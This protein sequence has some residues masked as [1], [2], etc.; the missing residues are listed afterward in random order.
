M[1]YLLDG[2]DL[3]LQCLNFFLKRLQTMNQPWKMTLFWI[4]SFDCGPRLHTFSSIF[5]HKLFKCIKLVDVA[6][7]HSLNMWKMNIVSLYWCSWRISGKIALLA[8]WI[9]ICVFCTMILH[10][11]K[12][13]FWRGHQTLEE[14][15]GTI[16]PWCVQIKKYFLK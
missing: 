14:H 3:D 5:K 16:L 8:I 13:S 1:E 12:N 10:Y 11:W 4:I 9:Y 6:C 2:C 15:K 7:V